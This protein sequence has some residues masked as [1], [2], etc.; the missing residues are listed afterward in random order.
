MVMRVDS[1]RMGK[2]YYNTNIKKIKEKI[3]K[4][5]PAKIWD[6][7]FFTENREIKI[8]YSFIRNSVKY[9]IMSREM[10]E[11]LNKKPVRPFKKWGKK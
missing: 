6:F 1:S 8:G 9:T 10:M 11:F 3:E 7:Q 5:A 4:I 2:K